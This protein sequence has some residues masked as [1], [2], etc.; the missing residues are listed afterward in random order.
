MSSGAA[1]APAPPRIANNLQYSRDQLSKL[2]IAR[3]TAAV[4]GFEYAVQPDG[5]SLAEQKWQELRRRAHS[6]FA[7]K[8]QP[9]TRISLADLERRVRNAQQ[10]YQQRCSIPFAAAAPQQSV[11]NSSRSVSRQ[12]PSPIPAPSAA[13]LPSQVGS[14]SSNSYPPPPNNNSSCRS[15]NGFQAAAALLSSANNGNSGRNPYSQSTHASYRPE[16]YFLA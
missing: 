7:L 11:S 13:A 14:N 1:G 8:Q 9:S 10:E 4:S 3:G 12:V 16:P 5:T 15:E 6:C 2:S